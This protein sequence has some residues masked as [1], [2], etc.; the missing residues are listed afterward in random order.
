MCD[1]AR[2]I[3]ASPYLATLVIEILPV[4]LLLH[5][6]HENAAW[7]Y[8]L[9]HWLFEH[10]CLYAHSIWECRSHS[11]SHFQTLRDK[12]LKPLPHIFCPMSLGKGKN[13]TGAATVSQKRIRGPGEVSRLRGTDGAQGVGEDTANKK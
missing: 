8:Q 3:W 12:K 13:T 5:G 1:F 4:T 11:G 9:T 10:F 7:P 2:V 6:H